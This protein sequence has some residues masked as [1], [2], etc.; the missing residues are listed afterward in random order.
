MNVPGRKSAVRKVKVF[1]EMESSFV[2]AAI[3]T[4]SILSF[5]VDALNKTL[6]APCARALRAS[7]ES[8]TP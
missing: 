1:I 2:E 5:W 8:T 4:L 6:V 3:L 7:N